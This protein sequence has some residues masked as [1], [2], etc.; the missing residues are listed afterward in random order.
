LTNAH[1]LTEGANDLLKK[2]KKK[3]EEKF[4]GNSSV[5]IS[6]YEIGKGLY[7]NLP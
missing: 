2:R 5:K 4:N 1:S 7:T 6:G 3:E